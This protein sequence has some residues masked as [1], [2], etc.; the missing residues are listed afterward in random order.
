M[1]L[2][3]VPKSLGRL[4]DVFIS[5]LGSI[6]GK[7]N[8]LGL[9]KVKSACVVLVD[10]LGAANIRYRAGHANFLASQLAIDGTIMAGFPS[11]TVTSLVSFSTGLR[12]GQ[13]AMVGYQVHDRRQGSNLNL[14]TGIGS[15]AE[16]LSWQPRK[17]VSEV[18]A[19]NSV[20]CYFI[21]PAEYET[22][23]FTNV[24][25][26]GAKYVAAKNLDDRVAA[27][28][29]ILAAKDSALVYLYV[30]E[31][32]QRAHAY[33]SKSGQWVEKLEDLDLAVRQLTT[34]LPGNVGV[35]L[36]ADHGIVDV[37]H[38]RQIYLDEL[39]INGLVSVGGDPRVLFLYLDSQQSDDALSQSCIKSVQEFVGK[40]AYVV[41]RDDLIAQGWYGE[42]TDEARER[43]PDIFVIA[44]GETALYHRQFAKPKSLQMIGQHGAISDDELFV[45][46]LRFGAYKKR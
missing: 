2:P 15:L 29:K 11:T 45:P 19:E 44:H 46:L 30:P 18:A 26:R 16:A 10:G 20:D 7:E 13:H 25:M 5:A 38:E 8:R 42:V 22:S 12:A 28:K 36:T 40:R 1:M 32:D 24:T 33:G 21:G 4:S 37:A 3:S 23:G 41:A 39:S 17:T 14:L 43:M 31:L 9:P 6:T 35:L 27:A 34:A